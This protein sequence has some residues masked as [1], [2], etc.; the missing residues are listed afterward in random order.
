[1][2]LHRICFYYV[3]LMIIR[4]LA[5]FDVEMLLRKIRE[6]KFF[7]AVRPYFDFLGSKLR[8]FACCTF[9]YEKSALH[10]FF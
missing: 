5:L 7:Y 2:K 4:N 3:D 8:V 1:M 10:D 9:G 6:I